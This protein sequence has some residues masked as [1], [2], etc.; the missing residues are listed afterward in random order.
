MPA[1]TLAALFTEVGDRPIH[2]L[3]IDVEGM[4]A[5]VLVGWGMHPAR[6]WIVVIEA[7]EP[8]SQTPNWSVWEPLVLGMDYEFF[9]FDGLNRFYISAEHR[10]LMPLFAAPPNIF[11]GFRK[12]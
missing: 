10:E 9:Y 8:S 1:T 2:W 11:D 12:N 6:P 5:D 4:E 7:T 3:K